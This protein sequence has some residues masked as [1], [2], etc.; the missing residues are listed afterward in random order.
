MRTVSLRPV[1]TAGETV[2]VPVGRADG[3][4]RPVAVVIADRN[5]ARLR[6]V[7]DVERLA[8]CAVTATALAAAAMAARGAARRRP[9]IGS[10]SMGPG[11]WVSLKGAPL[12][13]LRP[14]GRRP[15]WARLLRARRLVVE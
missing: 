12:P 3:C 7:V 11:G 1:T 9:A 15:W 2:V 8:W 14:A 5:G 6:P 10:V 4:G 13:P